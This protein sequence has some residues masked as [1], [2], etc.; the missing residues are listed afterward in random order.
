MSI[1]S[2]QRAFDILE[3]IAGYSSPVPL[4][5][6]ADQSGLSVSTVHNLVKTMVDRGYLV[7]VGA[8]G[9]FALGPELIELAELVPI[10]Y[11]VN[12]I[13]KPFALEL[14]EKAERESTYFS[15]MRK[16]QVI[17]EFFYPGN[18]SLNVVMRAE[19]MDDLHCSAQGKIYLAYMNPQ[20]RERY[21]K[22]RELVKHG[23]RTIENY[24]ELIENLEIVRKQGYAIN[25]EETEEGACGMAAPLFSADG[26]VLGTFAI[27]LPTIRMVQKKK[28]L[29]DTMLEV[30]ARAQQELSNHFRSVQ[31]M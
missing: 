27:G 10:H 21:L 31:Q 23:P 3:L 6:I 16:N 2:L 25:Y 13:V 18:Y 9:G 12:D 17:A 4:K 24:D 7:H 15:I 5:T 26:R 30:T 22:S 29:I 14:Y 20:Q 28:R 8:R 19:I 1:Q 11:H